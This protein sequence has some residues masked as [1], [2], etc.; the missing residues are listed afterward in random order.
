MEVSN[1]SDDE[2]S[3]V[4][5]QL[6]IYEQIFSNGTKTLEYKQQWYD[7]RNPASLSEDSEFLHNVIRYSMHNVENS[8]PELDAYRRYD[9]SDLRLQAAKMSI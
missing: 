9:K 3:S 7:N 5:I 6:F 4:N 8:P 1:F 2:Y